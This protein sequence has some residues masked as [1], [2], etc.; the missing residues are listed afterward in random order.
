MKPKP[1]P[2]KRLSIKTFDLSGR[3]ITIEWHD[4]EAL[5]WALAECPNYGKII[6]LPAI[7]YLC[8]KSNYDYNEVV[9]YLD[10]YNDDPLTDQVDI[11]IWGE[12]F[13]VR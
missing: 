12:A 10:S 3:L 4:A 2:I 8:V 5:A 9:A 13:D 11:E 7:L 6:E 1:Q